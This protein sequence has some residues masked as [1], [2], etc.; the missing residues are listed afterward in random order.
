MTHDVFISYSS[1]DVEIA[2]NICEILEDMDIGCWMA[3]RN[4]PC[5][6]AWPSSIVT[7]I[8]N[9]QLIILVFTENSNNSQYVLREVTQAAKNNKVMIPFLIENIPMC[10][11]LDFFLHGTQWLIGHPDYKKKIDELREIVCR[12]LERTTA[13]KHQTIKQEDNISY[14]LWKTLFKQLVS[15]SEMSF[16]KVREISDDI[17]QNEGVESAI[18]FWNRL[19]DENR[20]N[21]LLYSGRAQLYQRAQ[22][23]EF[24]NTIEN[25]EKEICDWSTAYA[26]CVNNPKYSKKL[27]DF[28]FMR[29]DDAKNYYYSI[30]RE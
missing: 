3:P 2:E 23:Q 25:I 1:T 20:N 15:E 18:A 5:G 13:K 28:Y 30:K 17:L 29:M 21:P 26:L 4:I 16:E 11:G 14:P 6:E 10:K 8:E 7:A 22:S 19:I 9:S 24:G 12:I 27:T